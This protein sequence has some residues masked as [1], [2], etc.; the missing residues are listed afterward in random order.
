VKPVYPEELNAQRAPI[1]RL[2]TLYLVG[3]DHSPKHRIVRFGL[4]YCSPGNGTRCAVCG[5][6]RK[7]PEC[8]FSAC[9]WCAAM[10]LSCRRNGEVRTFRQLVEHSSCG[11]LSKRRRRCP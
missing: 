6:S 3:V 10:S 1:G 2:L 9:S 11:Q 4:G 5:S 7:K 8:C